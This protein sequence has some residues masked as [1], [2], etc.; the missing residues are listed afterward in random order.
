M[1]ASTSRKEKVGM[2]KKVMSSIILC[3]ADKAQRKVATKKTAMSIWVKRESLYMTKSLA[4]ILCVET[5]PI[6]RVGQLSDF[7]KIL[8]DLE[9]I[10]VKL[11]DE[12]KD[13]LLLNALPKTYENFKDAWLFRK[14]Q[15]ITLEEV[16][17]HKGYK[18]LE[19]SKF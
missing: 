1:L 10:E 3:L 13:L 11:D 7:N 2:I 6:H 8:D 15:T 9:K 12:D 5:T 18:G 16:Q 17:I 14:E 4:H 19:L